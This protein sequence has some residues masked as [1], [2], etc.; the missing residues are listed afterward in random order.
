[1]EGAALVHGL[2]LDA[3]GERT[4]LLLRAQVYDL[5]QRDT[6]FARGARGDVHGSERVLDLHGRS[7]GHDFRLLRVEGEGRTLEV[8]AREPA[9]GAG[10]EMVADAPGRLDRRSESEDDQQQPDL[11]ALHRGDLRASRARK[12]ATS[13]ST[14]HRTRVSGHQPRSVARRSMRPALPRS[15][16]TPTAM[17]ERPSTST[18]G[19][20]G[21]A[22]AG[23]ALHGPPQEHD[24]GG[25][26][27][28][29]PV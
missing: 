23:L 2:E 8:A 11:R 20:N 6:D 19:L 16:A 24:A 13:S 1:A 9:P 22:I 10:P 21:R 3:I 15:Q 5:A 28:D 29:R 25:D 4:R 26:E 27:E 7:R 14:P 17:S 12:Y 18:S